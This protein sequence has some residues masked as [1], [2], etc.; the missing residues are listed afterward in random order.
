MTA[1]P[2]NLVFIQRYQIEKLPTNRLA[3]ILKLFKQS[4]KR[5]I[6]TVIVI[7]R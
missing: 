5:T 6:V 2:F 3:I 7:Y 1:I 4:Q